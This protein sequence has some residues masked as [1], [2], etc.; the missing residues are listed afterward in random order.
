MMQQILKATGMTWNFKNLQDL[1][2]NDERLLLTFISLERMLGTSCRP[3][4]D[5]ITFS[6][7]CSPFA[8]ISIAF[9]WSPEQA[10][11]NVPYVAA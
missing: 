4:N 9:T 1:E 5:M 6:T 2:W 7:F 10:K 8:S 11:Y 3:S